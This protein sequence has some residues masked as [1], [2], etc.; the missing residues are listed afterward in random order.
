MAWNQRRLS[1]SSGPA[2]TT[3]AA[4]SSCCRSC[5]RGPTALA[6]WFVARIRAEAY[7]A[8]G[9]TRA[10]ARLYDFADR[11]NPKDVFKARAI[12][13]AGEAG[14]DLFAR[15]KAEAAIARSDAEPELLVVAAWALFLDRSVDAVTA[16]SR[17]WEQVI[18]VT[19]RALDVSSLE[20]QMRV[21]GLIGRAAAHLCLGNQGAG[22]RDLSLAAELFPF[23]PMLTLVREPGANPAATSRLL[24]EAIRQQLVGNRPLIAVAA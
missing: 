4:G 15:R 19:S 10:A 23:H 1:I 11:L 6:T 7:A 9:L 17:V 16:D 12:M 13:L 22:W 24:V 14:D 21:N 3:L 5:G 18:K 2:C 8:L 20:E